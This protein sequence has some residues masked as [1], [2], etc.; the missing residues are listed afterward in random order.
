MVGIVDVFAVLIICSERGLNPILW[1]AKGRGLCHL[2]LCDF[3]NT[4]GIKFFLLVRLKQMLIPLW[5]R[6]AACRAS[7]GIGFVHRA[8]FV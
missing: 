5:Q 4:G 1:D 3:V 7:M 6:S 8:L 2:L